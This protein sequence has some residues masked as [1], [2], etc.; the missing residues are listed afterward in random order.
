MG[1]RQGGGA[2]AARLKVAHGHLDGRQGPL[3]LL[4]RVGSAHRGHRRTAVRPT[5]GGGGSPE[6][7]PPDPQGVWP[8]PAPST[9]QQHRRG[10]LGGRHLGQAEL[11]KA[12]GQRG[13][14]RARTGG[15]HPHPGPGGLLPSFSTTDRCLE[16]AED[17]RRDIPAPLLL[18]RSQAPHGQHGSLWP[19]SSGR[20][21]GPRPQQPLG[22]QPGRGWG[23]DDRCCKRGGRPRSLLPTHGS[24]AVDRRRSSPVRGEKRVSTA[25]SRRHA[26]PSRGPCP[27]RPVRVSRSVADQAKCAPPPMTHGVPIDQR[28]TG[29]RNKRERKRGPPSGVKLS[30]HEES[31]AVHSRRSSDGRARRRSSAFTSLGRHALPSPETTR[32]AAACPPAQVSPTTCMLREHGA[33]GCSHG[34]ALIG[35]NVRRM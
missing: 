20:T 8:P 18:G 30:A 33:C 10:G 24:T 7:R 26:G 6:R 14:P 16:S 21:V 3:W 13:H 17:R 23:R 19:H 1:G 12:L 27:A 35:R 34:R 9:R 4:H 28:R 22:S 31:S 11:L 29:P 15:H 2:A 25:I 5:G 32:S